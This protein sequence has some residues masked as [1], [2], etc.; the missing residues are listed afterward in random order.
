M[1]DQPQPD[2]VAVKERL[3]DLDRAIQAYVAEATATPASVVVDWSICVERADENGS[4]T[5]L[6]YF[7]PTMTPWKV[8]GFAEWS[9]H[10]LKQL[11]GSI[12][13]GN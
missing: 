3:D 8:S 10:R 6:S 13:H 12:L 4:R 9:Y 1:S 7:S 11:A 2:P 5:F